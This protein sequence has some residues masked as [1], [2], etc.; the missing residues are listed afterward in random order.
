VGC[1]LQNPTRDSESGGSITARV[2]GVIG[3]VKAVHPRVRCAPGLLDDQRTSCRYDP[4][5]LL[6]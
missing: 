5:E 6:V 2:L 1:G 4:V 3:R